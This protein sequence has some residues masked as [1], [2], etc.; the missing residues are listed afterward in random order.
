MTV[1]LP[2]SVLASGLDVLQHDHP[3]VEIGSYPFHEDGRFGSRLVLTGTDDSELDVVAGRL[4]AI[5]DELQGE[6]SWN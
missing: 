4:D 1:F 6:R 2:E 3:A 5:L